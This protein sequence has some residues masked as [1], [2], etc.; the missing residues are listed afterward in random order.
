MGLHVPFSFILVFWDTTCL[1]IGNESQE[2][3]HFNVGAM[4]FHIIYYLKEILL[5]LEPKLW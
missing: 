3:C 4:I 1:K 2:F 5:S